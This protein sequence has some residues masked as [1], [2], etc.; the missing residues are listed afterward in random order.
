[1]MGHTSEK[2]VRSYLNYHGYKVTGELRN[3]VS[4]MN[5]KAKNKPVNKIATNKATQR[6]ERLQMDLSGPFTIT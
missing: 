1:M 4:C 3:W 5:W 6:G 2:A